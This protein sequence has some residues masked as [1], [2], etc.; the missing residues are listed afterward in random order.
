MIKKILVWIV[1]IVVI[2]GAGAY[3]WARSNDMFYKVT[4]SER[5]MGPFTFVYM[6]RKG[7]YSKV[8]PE[9]AT[10]YSKV[11]DKYQVSPAKGFAIYYDAPNTVK[12]EDLRSD[13]GFL[14]EGKDANKMD[15]IM[16]TTKVRWIGPKNYVTAVFPLKGTASYVIGAI[17]CYPELS[18]YMQKKGYKAAPSF[19]LY[20]MAAKQIIYGFQI[21]R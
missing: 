2:A 19:E 21:V 18:R 6:S 12:T 1:V 5:Q 10:F 13:I 9:M 3:W 20:D 8:G 17:K 7:D 15:A 16:K 11:S 14:L 4:V